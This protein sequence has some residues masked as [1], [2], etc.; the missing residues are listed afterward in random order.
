MSNSGVKRVKFRKQKIRVR[1]R[2]REREMEVKRQ[3]VSNVDGTWPSD[4]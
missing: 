4:T 3:N 1:E 2:E